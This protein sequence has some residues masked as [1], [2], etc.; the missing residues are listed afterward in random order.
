MFT[1]V[2]SGFGLY[3]YVPA[4]LHAFGEP[5]ILPLAYRPK[6][7]GREDLRGY[8]ER[9]EWA[10]DAH[11]A[12]AEA[13]GVVLATIPAEQPALVARC[14]AAARIERIVVEKPVA[15]TPAQAD[16]VLARLAA[17]GKRYRIGYTLLHA[18]WTDRLPWPHERAV[19]IEWTFMAHHFARDLANW[20]RD[21]SQGGGVIRFFGVHLLA[22]LARRGY[23][24]VARSVVAGDRSGEPDRWE[25]EF[26]G[27]GLAPARV[28][29]DSRSAVERFSIAFDG[30]PAA[31]ALREPFQLESPA[32]PDDRRVPVLERLLA[33]FDRDDALFVELYAA[34]NRLWRRVEEA[35]AR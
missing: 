27:P 2:G 32:P 20:K 10:A 1:V 12:L 15:I 22:L 6:M 26:R 16:D 18:A 17:S 33:T 35:G 4:I 5:V 8:V 24:E 25:A 11:A 34:T 31:V 21:A 28:R 19:S 7:E 29:M 9:I 3:G 14:C 23:D 13:T 30:A